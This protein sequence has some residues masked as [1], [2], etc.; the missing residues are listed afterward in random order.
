MQLPPGAP[1]MIVAIQHHE[2]RI[3]HIDIQSHDVNEHT[4]QP[5]D[6]HHFRHHL[7]HKDQDHER[8]QR[9]S[10]DASFYE[11][12]AHELDGARYIAVIGHGTG[13]SNAAHHLTDYL[14]HSHPETAQRLTQAVSADLSALS[15][16]QILALGRK[17]IS[18]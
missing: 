9:A 6:P 10:E 13:H 1:D 7:T 11:R 5:H 16:P 3:F 8:G 14:K 15:D 18:S 12:I 17:A 4:I 2:A